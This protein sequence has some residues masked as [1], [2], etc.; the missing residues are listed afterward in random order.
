[1]SLS[2]QG[3]CRANDVADTQPAWLESEKAF[4]VG[5]IGHEDWLSPACCSRIINGIAGFSHFGLQNSLQDEPI[6]L[7]RLSYPSASDFF[8]DF[9]LRSVAPEQI[10]ELK[11]TG[12]EAAAR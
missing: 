8:L 10:L 4:G 5:R 1:M 11:F 2:C 7:D 3:P 12:R 9:C 6:G